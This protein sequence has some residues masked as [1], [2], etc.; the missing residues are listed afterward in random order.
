MNEQL[1]EIPDRLD[2]NNQ[3]VNQI[4]QGAMVRGRRSNQR[5]SILP[6]NHLDTHE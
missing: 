6:T 3:R 2:Q 4:Q 1:N 5:P